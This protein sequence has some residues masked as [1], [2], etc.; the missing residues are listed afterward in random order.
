[1]LSLGESQNKQ[2][3]DNEL[4]KQ[5]LWLH[6][7]QRASITWSVSI[8]K[9]MD[10]KI[11]TPNKNYFE[12]KESSESKVRVKQQILNLLRSSNPQMKLY[13]IFALSYFHKVKLPDELKKSILFT[14]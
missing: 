10:I 1:M 11:T 14:T 4:I 13:I 6:Y 9:S 12:L 8:L 5:Y 7:G 3:P 2:K